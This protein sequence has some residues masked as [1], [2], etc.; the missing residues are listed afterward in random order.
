[1]LIKNIVKINCNFS[2]HFSQNI[3]RK[4]SLWNLN[5]NLNAKMTNF[6]GWEMPLHYS[7]GILKEHLH[8]RSKAG[9]FDVS[10]M[11]GVHITGK[12]KIEFA[13]KIFPACISE[14]KYGE[15]LLTNIPNEKGG[16]LDDCILT[17]MGDYLHIVINAGHEDIDIPHMN[18]YLSKF[19]GNVQL[20][21]QYNNSIIALQGPSSHYVLSHYI[22]EDTIKNWAFMT[23]KYISI[24][25]ID[26]LIARSGYTGED[27]FEITCKNSDA[28]KLATLLLSNPEVNP[29]GLGARDSLRLEAGLC[30]YGNDINN[31]TTPIEAMLGWTIGKRRRKEANFIGANIICNQIKDKNLVTRK[32]IGFE[33]DGPP[34]RGNELLLDLNEKIIGFTTSGA[35]GPSIKKS[36]G[37]GY[38][39]KEFAKKGSKL[40]VQNKRGK[41]QNIYLKK[42][43]FIPTNIFKN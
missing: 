24:D 2:R 27:G 38:V 32:R 7:D 23:M 43:P 8:C 3:L 20:I 11:L 37:M 29:I 14:L 35:Y 30:L 31:S 19:N 39:K 16:L 42:M 4:T 15:G 26:C 33:I 13:E 12:D 18:K 41:I 10:H 17:N 28:E 40:K 25:K 22:S 9:L 1:M 5:K 34:I 21:P 36:I 6:S